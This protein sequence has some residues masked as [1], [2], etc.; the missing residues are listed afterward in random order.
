[1]VGSFIYSS[2]TSVPILTCIFLFL[3]RSRISRIAVRL[4]YS[5]HLLYLTELDDDTYT[6]VGISDLR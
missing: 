3:L 2:K 4:V 1:M 5:L 6:V